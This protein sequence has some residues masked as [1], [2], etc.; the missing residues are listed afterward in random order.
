MCLYKRPCSP[1]LFPELS[2]GKHIGEVCTYDCH[3]GHHYSVD[4]TTGL[5]YWTHRDCLWQEMNRNVPRFDSATQ[6]RYGYLA[7]LPVPGLLHR[8]QYS[9]C[10]IMVQVSVHVFAESDQK[11]EPVIPETRLSKT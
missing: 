1:H 7:S 2:V 8:A 6:K 10:S 9:D 3:A 11:L 4:W 5:D